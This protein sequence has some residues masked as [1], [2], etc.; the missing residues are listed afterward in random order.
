LV[1]HHKAQREHPHVLSDRLV[2]EPLKPALRPL[3]QRRL[4]YSN[5]GAPSIRFCCLLPPPRTLSG[6]PEHCRGAHSTRRNPVVKRRNAPRQNRAP[7]WELPVASPRA[8]PPHLRA[9]NPLFMTHAASLWRMQLWCGWRESNPHGMP[10][11]ILSP[12]RIPVPPQPQGLRAPR[13]L[14]PGY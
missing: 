13:T 4:L 14:E 10:Q 3:Q 12:P 6:P 2:K 9:A 7:S 5:P 1:L 11:R 8:R